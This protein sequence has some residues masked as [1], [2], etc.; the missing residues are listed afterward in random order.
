MPDLSDISLKAL[1]LN[2]PKASFS[3]GSQKRRFSFKSKPTNDTGKVDSSSGHESNVLLSRSKSCSSGLIKSTTRGQ[4]DDTIR[5]P[6]KSPRTA[7][8]ASFGLVSTVQSNK[9]TNGTTIGDLVHIESLGVEGILRYLGPVEGRK[10]TWA[11]VELV[12]DSVG[13]GKNDGSVAGKRYFSCERDCGVF[14][15]A[16]RLSSLES[17]FSPT[18]SSVS[19][20]E[21]TSLSAFSDS[22]PRHKLRGDGSA[23]S[24]RVLPHVNG[25]N[26][27]TSTTSVRSPPSPATR[28]ARLRPLSRSQTQSRVQSIPERRK[29]G[30]ELGLPVPVPRPLFLSSNSSGIVADAGISEAESSD[31]GL[32]LEGRAEI[33]GS[34]TFGC[35]TSPTQS[36]D[37]SF[38]QLG[39]TRRTTALDTKE[40]E[41][42]SRALQERIASLIGVPTRTLPS[43]PSMQ[44]ASSLHRTKSASPPCSPPPSLIKGSQPQTRLQRM[45]SPPSPRRTYSYSSTYTRKVLSAPS[46]PTKPSRP[47]LQARIQPKSEY[48]RRTKSHSTHLSSSSVSSSLE[49]YTRATAPLKSVGPSASSSSRRQLGEQASPDPSSPRSYLRIHTDTSPPSS[50]VPLHKR[51]GS[52][53]K[54]VSRG[55]DS[56]IDENEWLSRDG[57][58]SFSPVNMD[59]I[60]LD[61]E[62]SVQKEGKVVRELK[63]NRLP[64][65]S[66]STTTASLSSNADSEL[67]VSGEHGSRNGEGK[68]VYIEKEIQTEEEPVPESRHVVDS[69]GSE[70]RTKAQVSSMQVEIDTL[71][72][73][74]DSL[75]SM[76]K[77]KNRETEEKD[78]VL[79]TERAEF[80]ALNARVEELTLAGRETIALYEGKLQDAEGTRWELERRVRELELEQERTLRERDIDE[81]VLETGGRSDGENSRRSSITLDSGFGSDDLGNGDTSRLE[82]VAFGDE[83][84]LTLS[85]YLDKAH[86]H[87]HRYQSASEID[88]S[89]LLEQISHLT[90][91]VSSLEDLVEDQRSS[92]DKEEGLFQA[93]LIEYQENEVRLKRQ[94]AELRE[95]M[96]VERERGDIEEERFKVRLGETEEALTECRRALEE[97][98]GEVE[99]LKGELANVDGL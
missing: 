51:S 16:T 59:S 86:T 46:S 18:A 6:K 77:D 41:A 50:F 73:E 69:L 64:V 30:I 35:S 52:R 13:K 95:E 71:N 15:S 53:P 48:Q 29:S 88:H 8:F 1:G 61:A 84:D 89:T 17:R 70:E 36:D 91:K 99:M 14:V 83:E 31:A 10:G 47:Q 60:G 80:E 12:G 98:R 90:R 87:H 92:F 33:A 67:S 49:P 85:K 58:R 24:S 63:E 9:T 19:S 7:S 68:C 26:T 11:G 32:S 94:L 96:M 74:L 75:R 76:L 28:T 65:S 34:G 57:P 79:A 81:Y 22:L 66:R 42:R 56:S 78:R 54:V 3:E 44:P 2:S 4:S 93:R 55:Y 20:I 5:A 40:L 23:S 25:R 37:S 27:S 39:C 43:P 62:T 45:D 82:E 21:Q 38:S 72:A 97:A